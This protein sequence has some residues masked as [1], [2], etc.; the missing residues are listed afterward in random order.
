MLFTNSLTNG[1]CLHTLT[2]KL[3]GGPSTSENTV[4][5]QAEQLE[6]FKQLV[7]IEPHQDV[8][9]QGS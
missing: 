9:P 7:G 1:N 5:S 6:Y 2:P 8:V 4:S 3:S